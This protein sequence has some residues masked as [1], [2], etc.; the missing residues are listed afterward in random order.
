MKR[1]S[2]RKWGCYLVLL[3]HRRF[4]VKL[5][6]FKKNGEISSQY[7]HHRSE[8]WL[9]LKGYGCFSTNAE[10][11]QAGGG[12][13]AQAGDWK[14]VQEQAVHHYKAA[15]TTYVLEIQYGNRCDEGDIVRV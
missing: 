7:H 11:Q 6:R 9:F 10:V 15:E 13:W 4:K 12:F 8:L 5:L 2:K 14:H 3:N 1:F